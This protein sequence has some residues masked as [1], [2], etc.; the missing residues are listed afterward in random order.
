MYSYRAKIGLQLQVG[1]DISENFKTNPI[2]SFRVNDLTCCSTFGIA[3]IPTRDG[4]NVNFLRVRRK[5]YLT[6]ESERASGEAMFG[7]NGG[8]IQSDAAGGSVTERVKYIA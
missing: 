3:R 8:F 4:W 1:S 5:E 6:L 2:A 7:Q